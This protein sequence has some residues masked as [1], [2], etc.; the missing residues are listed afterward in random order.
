MV[1]SPT[2]SSDLELRLKEV[3]ERLLEGGVVDETVSSHETEAFREKINGQ[4]WLHPPFRLPKWLVGDIEVYTGVVL[5][6]WHR[7]PET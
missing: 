1:F 5:V 7:L 2:A 6:Y 4:K 3:S